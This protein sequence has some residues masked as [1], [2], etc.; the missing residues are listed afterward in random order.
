MPWSFTSAPQFL[1]QVGPLS[2]HASQR[3]SSWS[4]ATAGPASYLGV[5]A[6]GR[7]PW[8]SP[9][10]AFPPGVAVLPP[11]PF[12]ALGV[13]GVA[14]APLLPVGGLTVTRA[15]QLASFG[16]GGNLPPPSRVVCRAPEEAKVLS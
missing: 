12:L 10:G 14:G 3:F 8:S 11:L 9:C 1:P 15:P 5:F 6:A 16:R 4:K 2:S 13:A 7:S